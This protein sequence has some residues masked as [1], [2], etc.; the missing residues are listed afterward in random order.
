MRRVNV[1]DAYDCPSLRMS[2][3]D[4][5]PQHLSYRNVDRNHVLLML[6][7]RLQLQLLQPLRYLVLNVHRPMLDHRN[8]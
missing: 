2:H 6:L 4:Y 8:C 1:L 3:N 5:R 7:R